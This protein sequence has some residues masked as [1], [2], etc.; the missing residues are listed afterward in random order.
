MASIG[1]QMKMAKA[2]SGVSSAVGKATGAAKSSK[3]AENDDSEEEDSGEEELVD[4]KTDHKIKGEKK[5]LEIGDFM[6]DLMEGFAE[7]YRL[8]VNGGQTC[9]ECVRKTTYP[10]KESIIGAYDGVASQVNPSTGARAA[11]GRFAATP[12]FQHE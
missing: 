3:A 11:T 8:A 10:I 7:L 4:G 9:G 6:D 12:T 2:A 5:K 1:A